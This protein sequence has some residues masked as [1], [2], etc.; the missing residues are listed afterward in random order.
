MK[1]KKRMGFIKEK[2]VEVKNVILKAKKAAEMTDN[3][4]RE[5]I[6]ESRDWEKSVKEI[7]SRKEKAEEDSVG[8]DIEAKEI[9]DLKEEVQNAVDILATKIENLKKE[10][11]TRGLFTAVSKNLSRENVIFPEAFAG[12]LGENVF[13]FKDKFMQAIHDSQVREK[14]QVE[15]LRKHLTGEA[16]K[17]VGGH[18]KSLDSAMDALEEYFGDTAKIWEKCKEMSRRNLEETLVNPGAPTGIKEECWLLQQ[19]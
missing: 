9:T 19:Q 2:S 13:K 18:H 1:L 3:E 10:D 15:V 4:I 11:K 17:L 12:G 14:D 6:I 8:L 16:K 5:C 7:V